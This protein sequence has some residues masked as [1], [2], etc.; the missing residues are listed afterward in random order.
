[1]KEGQ[2]GKC[3]SESDWKTVWLGVRISLV[4]LKRAIAVIFSWTAWIAESNVAELLYS[5]TGIKSRPALV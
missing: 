1:M 2:Y 3:P 5:V 4:L